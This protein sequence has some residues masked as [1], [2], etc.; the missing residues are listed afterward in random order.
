MVQATSPA[1]LRSLLRRYNLAPRKRLGQHF[2]WQQLV[3]E[4]MAEA[5]ELDTSDLVL[6][7]GPGL[8]ILTVACAERAGRVIAVEID[9]SLFPLL[10]AELGAYPNVRLVQGDAR[11][12]DFASLARRLAPDSAGH[13]KVLG[14]LPY[15]LTSPLLVS[16]LSGGLQAELMVLMVQQEVAGRI[17]AA[18]G[19]KEYG[20]LSVL[21]QYH[22]TAEMLFKVAPHD[23]WPQPEVTSAV[24]RLRPRPQPAVAVS[25]P[26]LFFLVVRGAFRYRRKTLRNA[27]GEAGLLP[28]GNTMS[29]AAGP[30]GSGT[31]DT[32]FQEA[33]IDP[34][35]RGETLNLTEFACLAEALARARGRLLV[36]ALH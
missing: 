26:D 21:V 27:L 7:I 3:V 9:E 29:Q 22:A 31:V 13:C 6:E 8:G 25:D 35:R 28:A 16:L 10:E 23:F 14:N 11:R 33:R 30:T 1:A 20:S 12:V 17:V 4:R 2:L 36:D 24:I 18:P 15:Y 5:A 34:G 32:L 19:S